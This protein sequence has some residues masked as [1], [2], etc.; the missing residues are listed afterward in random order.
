[1]DATLTLGIIT[2]V[3]G[4][5]ILIRFISLKTRRLDSPFQFIPTVERRF[6]NNKVLTDHLG[7]LVRNTGRTDV[8]SRSIFVWGLAAPLI[9]DDRFARTVTDETGMNR[10]FVVIGSEQPRTLGPGDARVAV[11]HEVDLRELQRLPGHL[12]GVGIWLQDGQ[13]LR[14]LATDLFRSKRMPAPCWIRRL[15]PQHLRCPY[16]LTQWHELGTRA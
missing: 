7:V 12:W 13:Y 5:L 6:S 4:V 10:Y 14:V 1:M 11:I 2:A 15:L 16:T 3:T 9:G 8:A